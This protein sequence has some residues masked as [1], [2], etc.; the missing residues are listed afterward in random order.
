MDAMKH[1]NAIA[2][3]PTVGHAL[4]L[5]CVL[6][7]LGLLPASL[8]QDDGVSERLGPSSRRTALVISEIAYAPAP[9]SDGRDLEFVEL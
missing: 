6:L 3:S 2:R 4:V 1:P 7:A 5:G 9:R 8:A